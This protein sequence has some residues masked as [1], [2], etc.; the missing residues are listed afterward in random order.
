MSDDI[1]HKRD[2]VVGLYSGPRWREKVR[3][4]TDAQVIAIYMREHNKVEKPKA[5]PE[6]KKESKADDIPF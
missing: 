6:A 4:M 3:K 5:Q 1:H 2:F